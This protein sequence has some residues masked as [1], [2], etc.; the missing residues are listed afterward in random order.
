MK[1]AS[2]QPRDTDAFDLHLLDHEGFEI[3]RKLQV[4]VWVYDI[5]KARIPF[6]NAA[7]C[8]LWQAES[9]AELSARNMGDG[10]SST[11]A[12]RLKQYQNDFIETS[13]TFTELWTLYPNGKPQNVMVV[14]SGLRLADGRMAMLCE[15][16]NTFEDEPENVRSAE[17]LL[18]T[19]VMI[20]LIG[21]DGPALYMNPAARNVVP[22]IRKELQSLFVDPTDHADLIIALS[23]TGE[24]RL[25]AEVHTAN[26]N[27]WFDISAKTCSDAATGAP[28]IL[29]TAIDVSEL[30][31]ARDKARY[32][33]DRDLLTGCYNRSFLQSHLTYLST[34]DAPPQ[35]A[36]I[37]FDVDRFKQINDRFGHEVGDTVLRQI[38]NRARGLI[39]NCDMI[40]RLG[41]DEFLIL[42]EGI[43]SIEEIDQRVEE[44]RDVI[45]K[46]IF[47]EATRINVTVSMGISV[48]TPGQADFTEVMRHA[49]IAL[50]ASK[51]AGRNRATHF[52]EDMGR[53]AQQRNQIE[54]ELKT[55]LKRR[56]FVLFYQPRVDLRSG[57]VVSVE[58]LVR[59]N[60]P[61]RGLVMPDTF[62]PVCE[63][64]GMIEDLGREVL[65]VGCGQ[66][67]AWHAAGYDFEVSLNISPRQ[68]A[69]K[70]LL[71]TL[72]TLAQKPGFPK[73]KIEL[74]I[75]ENVLF[76]DDRI[77]AKK[78][79]TI[80]KMGYRIAI[81]DFGTGYSNLSYISRFPLNC[82]KIDRS[83]V[84][85][86]PSSGP[87]ISL[88]LTLAHQIGAIVVAEGVETE[89]QRDWLA[90]QDCEQA[91]GYF[92]SRPVP[93]VQF[94][95][96][97]E[98][99]NAQAEQ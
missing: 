62:I 87:I 75:T 70:H 49:D 3:A 22:N 26:G 80:T 68:F 58:G 18:H 43:G 53:A 78:L 48:F 99:L 83:F 30:K 11:V 66:A 69:D 93:P 74:E 96:F 10:M 17:A 44:L 95:E 41:G 88:I 33:A 46:P 89:E 4:P 37:F 85:Q 90:N 81:D 19:D 77:I 8:K 65:E 76:G 52:N 36:I 12:K 23:A 14:Y 32:L 29:V 34:L 7:A 84:D 15:A 38:S 28:A 20:M 45:S 73:G 54:E 13:A 71:R 35:C 94:L 9:E 6:A 61:T 86:L 16:I 82:L 60:H 50:Y 1:I 97:A 91:Q 56:E 51:E 5:D 47:H 25:V 39:R 63:E 55:A 59:W 72:Y 21:E 31:M 27:R 2:I 67:I 98:Q 79:Q 64:T 40:T 24:H 42:L 92:L 57:R